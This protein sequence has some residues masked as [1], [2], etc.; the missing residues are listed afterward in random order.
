MPSRW[1]K[2]RQQ[3]LNIRGRRCEFCGKTEQQQREQSNG[4][5]EIHHIIPDKY[6]GSDTLG[7]LIPLCTGCHREITMW[8]NDKLPAKKHGLP[9][10]LQQFIRFKNHV[11]A[12]WIGESDFFGEY[13]TADDVPWDPSSVGSTD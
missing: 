2:I 3:V 5:I 6:G 4:P 7:N 10:W 9:Y 8:T 11:R 12:G 1:E 13:V